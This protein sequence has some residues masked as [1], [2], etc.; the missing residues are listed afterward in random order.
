MFL[1]DKCHDANKHIDLFR[2]NGRCEGC[3][4]VR[5]CIDCHYPVCNAPKTKKE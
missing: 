5:L 2:S 1:C 4:K 3:G